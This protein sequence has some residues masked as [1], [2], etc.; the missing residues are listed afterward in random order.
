M[1]LIRGDE[2]RPE[3]QRQVLARY[4]H[5]HTVENARQSY[6]GRCPNCEQ[7][8]AI[9]FRT[10]WPGDAPKIW[11]RDE[12]HAYHTTHGAPLVT[13]AEWLRAHA[14]YV[15]RSGHLD[16]RRHYAEPAIIADREVT[17]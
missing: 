14:F 2:L 15:T 1:P 17:P 10:G 6:H 8:A 3:L 7:M 4:V 13:D 11:T 12:W 16:E 9:G 5:R